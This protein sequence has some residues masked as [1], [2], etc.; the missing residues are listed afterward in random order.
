MYDAMQ[1]IRIPMHGI[2]IHILTEQKV[3]K[4]SC[5]AL[6]CWYKVWTVQN[7]GKR[8]PGNQWARCR[9]KF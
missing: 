8:N 6:Q 9:S 1:E 7:S 5:Y 4:Q 2:K 3:E